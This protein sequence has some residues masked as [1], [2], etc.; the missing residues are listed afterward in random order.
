MAFWLRTEG[1]RLGLSSNARSILFCRY[2][3]RLRR[4]K[5]RV[6]V[7]WTLSAFI[8]GRAGARPDHSIG[9]HQGCSGNV[10]D[11]RS[12][13][14]ARRGLAPFH[15]SFYLM[16]PIQFLQWVLF[17]LSDIQGVF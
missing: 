5:R 17:V 12:V 16:V 10:L 14:I 2:R 6:S 1:T 4:S 9:R 8:A 7:T 13:P 3:C 11:F 15:H